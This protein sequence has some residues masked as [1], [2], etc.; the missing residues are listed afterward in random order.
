[1][2]DI[3]TAADAQERPSEQQSP[4]AVG[5]P[6]RITVAIGFWL[7]LF[8]FLSMVGFF[9]TLAPPER[10]TDWLPGL[11]QGPIKQAILAIFAA[12]VGSSISS[13]VAYLRHACERR[14]FELY[15]APW[16]IGRPIM[17]MLLGL[18]FY[19]VLRG[20]L[21]ATTISGTTKLEMG[22]WAIAAFAA[23]VGMFSKNAIEKLREVFHTLFRT[24]DG[25]SPG[26]DEPR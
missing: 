15:Y 19:F 11:N 17:G 24:Q 16:Y 4:T 26:S 10:L 20:G 3:E 18:I 2:P 14:D 1:M 21:L 8:A 22:D 23:L 7:L 9:I 12:G 5:F 13:I 25:A 6:A